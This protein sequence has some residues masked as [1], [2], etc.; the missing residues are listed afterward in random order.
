[1]QLV[2]IWK[3]DLITDSHLID[4]KSESYLSFAKAEQNDSCNATNLQALV[5]IY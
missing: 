5:E 3:M 2:T 4:Y 1:M